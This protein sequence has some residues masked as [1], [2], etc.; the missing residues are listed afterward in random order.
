MRMN[1]FIV[2]LA[3]AVCSATALHAEVQGKKCISFGWEYGRLTPEQLLA[4][5]DK[6]KGTAIDGV[7]IYLRATNRAG[8]VIGTSGFMTNPEWDI[9]AFKDQIPVLRK[10]ART[11]HLGESFLKCFGAPTKRVPWTDD[12]AWARIARNMGVVGRLS[13]ETG[14][15]GINSDPEDYHNQRQYERVKEDPPYGELVK[16]VR[17]RGR[18]VFGALFREQPEAR[19]LFYW[20]LTMYRQYFECRDPSAAARGKRDLWIAFADGIMDVLPPT[21]RIIDGNEN[22]YYYDYA[23]REFYVSACDQRLVAPKLLSPENRAKHAAQVQVGFALYLDMYVNEAGAHHYKGPVLGSRL[24]H[25]RRDC[26]DAFKL[27]DEYV[28]LWGEKHP[29]IRWENASISPSIRDNTTWAEALPGLYQAMQEC[30]DPSSGFRSRKAELAAK[31]ELKDMVSNPECRPD[32]QS[33][34]GRLPRPYTI[35]SGKGKPVFRLADGVGDGDASCIAVS[36]VKDGCVLVNFKDRKPHEMYAVSCRMKG[37]MPKA[38]VGWK[39]SK[40]WRW[41]LGTKWL[42]FSEP[43]ASGWQTVEAFSGVPEEATLVSYGLCPKMDDDETVFIDNVHV[44]QL[45]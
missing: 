30:D 18:E 33:A 2:I 22:S 6:F 45:W 21:A 39:D 17:R 34:K 19:V 8:K 14:L 43:D 5:A 36:G 23:K 32:D 11:E 44:W 4:N 37:S 25:F 29:T 41:D 28:W 15:K 26:A 24:E 12:A 27:A 16:I 3:V 7:G 10:I 35:Y 40:G 38:Y 42:N 1:V 31:G 13:R 9:E 20:F